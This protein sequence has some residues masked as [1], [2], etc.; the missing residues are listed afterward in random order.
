[1]NYKRVPVSSRFVVLLLLSAV[2][3][4]TDHKTDLLQPIRTATSIIN[5]PVETLIN[6]PRT[7]T[8]TVERF[9]P[10]SDLQDRY[11]LLQQKQTILES[12]LQRYEA[13]LRENRRLMDLLSASQKASDEFSLAEIINFRAEVYTHKAVINLGMESGVYIGQPVISPQGVIGQVVE[14][15]YRRSVLILISDISHGLPVEIERN[16]LRTIAQGSGK[17]G[18]VKVP[19][20]DGQANIRIGDRLVTSG[21]GGRFPAGYQV[22][23]VTDIVQDANEAFIDITAETTAQ[24]DHVREVALLWN[25]GPENKSVFEEQRLTAD[26]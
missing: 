6:I 23:V 26:E 2:L 5:L 19:Y 22:A 14:T 10:D 7:I 8:E 15:G 18:L 16:G 25:A 9:Y 24:I 3:M 17:T 20:L 21:I 11:R 4:V 12:R 1:M 13:V